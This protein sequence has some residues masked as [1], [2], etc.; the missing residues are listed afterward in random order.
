[1]LGISVVFDVGANI[2]QTTGEIR[3]RFPGATLG[4]SDRTIATDIFLQPSSGRNSVSKN[5]D[6]CL[7]LVPV[8]LEYARWYA[9]NVAR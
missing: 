5:I 3:E 2:V 6:R 9:D 1:V 8:S 4:F 7:G